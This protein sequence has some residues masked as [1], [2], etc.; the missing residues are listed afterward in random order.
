MKSL[1]TP[2]GIP[3]GKK[4]GECAH[5]GCKNTIDFHQHDK[6]LPGWATLVLNRYAMPSRKQR[7]SGGMSSVTMLLCPEHTISFATRQPSLLGRAKQVVRTIIESPFAGNVQENLRYLR[8][9]MRHSL[10]QG[11]AP[12][13]SHGLYTQEGVLDDLKPEER[14]L[15]MNAGFA[16]GETAHK[17][18]VYTDLGI[19]NGMVEGIKRAEDRGQVVEKRTLPG[20]GSKR[21]MHE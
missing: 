18:A 1:F 21:E 10:L 7:T 4:D 15:G 5:P 13:A 20:W 14:A 16:W 11:E 9:A 6:P 2:D 8:A 17:V 3:Y 12:Y 19:S